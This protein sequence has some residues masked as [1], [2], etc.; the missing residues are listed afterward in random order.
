MREIKIIVRIDEKKGKINVL[1][2]TILGIPPGID[3]E[4]YLHAIYS[5]LFSKS[6]K[7]FNSRNILRIEKWKQIK[8]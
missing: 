8:K 7:K 5:Y 1:E 2:E 6:G 4:L 3:R